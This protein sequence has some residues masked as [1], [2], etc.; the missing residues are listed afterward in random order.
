MKQHI[1]QGLLPIQ[2]VKNYPTKVI[3]IDKKVTKAE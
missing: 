1:P 2:R 3:N